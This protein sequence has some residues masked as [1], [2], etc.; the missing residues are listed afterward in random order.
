MKSTCSF[1]FLL[2]LGACGAT[3]D[4]TEPAPLP[5]ELRWE[6]VSGESL[7]LLADDQVL[8]RFQHSATAKHAYFHPL[9]LPGTPPL[10]RDAPQ[11]HVWHHGLWFCWKFINGVNYWEHARGEERPAGRTRW[12]DVEIE[13]HPD[14][15]A[16]IRMQLEYAPGEA[17]PVL[18]ERRIVEVTAPLADGS[19]FIDWHAEF[20]ALAETVE[21]ERTPL[22]GEPGGQVFGGY[23][24]LSLRLVNL[25]E[26]AAVTP[27][28]AVEFN[29]QSRYRGRH[30]AFEYNGTLDGRP[31]G[32]AVLDRP[33]NPNSPSPW[34][35]IRSRD[36]TFFTPAVICY[37]PMR[38]SRGESFTLRY[39]IHV[40]P[41]RWD[42]A[43]LADSL[44]KP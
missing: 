7:A 19:Y 30:A 41:G 18:S 22:P 20:T 26:R 1:L 2:A 16:R 9:A 23:A 14:H 12:S 29:P 13:P 44:E 24:G 21:L 37:E 36:M 32:I 28:G 35:A 10:T 8:W 40:H 39:R 17:A 4:P 42:A 6:E 11:D 31:V 15:S 33:D 27:A 25:E 34:Y 5:F 38:L 3:P 43:R